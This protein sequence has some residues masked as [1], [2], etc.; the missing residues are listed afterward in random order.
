MKSPA[1]VYI[2]ASAP[3]LD[4]PIL[5]AAYRLARTR[6]PDAEVLTAGN[7]TS[8]ADWKARREEVLSRVDVFII[9]P[10]V[11][12]IVYGGAYQDLLDCLSRRSPV[13]CGVYHGDTVKPV[14]ADPFEPGDAPYAF[15]LRDVH[16]PWAEWDKLYGADPDRWVAAP[17]EAE[18]AR[19][20]DDPL[21]EVL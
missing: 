9:A 4:G 3:E 8:A 1:L 16:R 19:H 10:S 11:D 6:W 5:R 17:L 20:T 7:F 21:P 12:G 13:L 15:R 18:T 14:L 2:S